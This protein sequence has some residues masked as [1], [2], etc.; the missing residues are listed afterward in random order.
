MKTI[1]PGSVLGILGGGQLGRML[2]LAAQQMG[3][4][5]IAYTTEY[6][7]PVSQV[8]SKTIVSS[9]D[10]V[11]ALRL[12]AREADIV[13]LE[14]ENI[15]ASSYKVVAEETRVAPSV[16]ALQVSQ[17]RL[18]EKTYLH[19]HGFPVGF[20]SHD[21]ANNG[22]RHNLLHGSLRP[23]VLTDRLFPP[24]AV[25]VAVVRPGSARHRSCPGG[26]DFGTA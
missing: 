13:T 24:T 3:Y 7:S 4:R 26:A 14:F 2:A 17:N 11:D 23:H 6:D 8:C 1:L 25:P 15:P 16:N 19:D 18:R 5:V 12:F 10:D 9:F 22:F 20:A 21:H